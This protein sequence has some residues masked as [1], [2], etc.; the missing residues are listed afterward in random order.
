M[1]ALK[2]SLPYADSL[3]VIEDAAS[4]PALRAWFMGPL[5]CAGLILLWWLFLSRASTKEKALGFIGLVTIATITTLLADKSIRGA[6]TMLYAVP[7]GI[8]GFAVALI[9]LA[10]RLSLSRTWLALLVALACFGFWDLVRMDGMW[11]N[12]HTSRSWRWEPTAEDLL[13][14]SVTSRSQ[15]QSDVTTVAEQVLAE[16]EWPAFRGPHRNGVQPGIVLAED[17]TARPLRELWRVRVG[18][19]WSSF[20]VAD[21]RLF[22]QEQRGEDELVVCYDATSGA[23]I[24]VHQDTTRFWEAMGGAGPRATPTLSEGKLFALG[25]LGLLNRLDPVTG[26]QVWQRDISAD[27]G[28][29]PPYWGYASSPLVTHDVVIVHSGGPQDKGMLAYDVETGDL[30]WTSPTGDHSYSSPQLSTVDGKQ[31]VLML[32]N[33]GITFVDPADGKLLGKHDWKYDGYRVVQPL[34][35]D[36]SSVLLGSGIGAGTQRIEVHW[37]GEQFATETIWMSRR[38]SPDFN[39]SVTHN[40]YLYGFDNNI[41]ACV[42]IATGKRKWKK[43]R[44]GNGQ[45][46]LLPAAG[47]LLVISETGELVLLRATPQKLEELARYQVLNGRTWNHPVLVGHRLY[48]RNG[49]EAACFEVPIVLPAANY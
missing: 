27:A 32:T 29:E 7:W 31:S 11:G 19:G 9:C 25:A 6:G 10:R 21:A 47:Q 41:F 22:T 49:A 37:D 3:V 34:V 35:L 24:W 39:D 12:F 42:D 18:P 13:L 1:W 46:L 2:L 44:Y 26:Q 33:T 17:W 36:G 16:A 23:E 43:G 40:G 28:R 15:K 14:S 20:S 45:V 30:R 48:V 8:S 38:M 4:I 5:V